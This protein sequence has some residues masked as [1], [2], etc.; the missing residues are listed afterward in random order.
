MLVLG[1][2]TRLANLAGKAVPSHNNAPRSAAILGLSFSGKTLL[3]V[4]A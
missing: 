3:L 2:N 1:C 4:Y